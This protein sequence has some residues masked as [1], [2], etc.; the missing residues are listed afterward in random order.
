MYVLME[1]YYSFWRRLGAGII[2]DFVLLPSSFFIIQFI[3]PLNPY[4]A[5]GWTVAQSLFFILYNVLLTGLFGQTAGKF[6]LGIK[7][8]DIHEKEVIGI[9][10][11][12]YRD[13]VPIVLEL[14]GLLI[15]GLI[16]SGQ[17]AS[18]SIGTFTEGV[19]SNVWLWWFIAE[20]LT[21]FLNPKRRAIH[22]LLASSVVISFKGLR[23]DKL[24]EELETKKSAN[25][26]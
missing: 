4:S 5:F 15:S 14:L 16:I 23:Y 21:M 25:L 17:I 7:V 9:K 26:I 10:R 8:F 6:L 22:D 20:L 11:A 12:F 1:R 18:D 24:D 13:A 2:D 3:D 19:I